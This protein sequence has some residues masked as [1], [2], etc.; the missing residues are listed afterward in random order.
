MKNLRRFLISIPLAA[1]AVFASSF[2]HAQAWPSKP[3]RIIVPVLPGAFTDLAARALAREFGEQLGQ[4]FLVENRS[5][6]GATLGAD[7]VAKSAPDGYTFLFTENGF[8]MAPAL[9]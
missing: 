9:Y 2:A 8:T 6:A 1:I 3:V 5:G 7:A 4:Q